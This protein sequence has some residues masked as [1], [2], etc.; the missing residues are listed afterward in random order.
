MF[1]KY[2]YINYLSMSMFCYIL[3]EFYHFSSILALYIIK[4][5]FF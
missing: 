4:Y 5:E 3:I 1:Q 2:M